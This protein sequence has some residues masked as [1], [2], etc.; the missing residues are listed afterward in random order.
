VPLVTLHTWMDQQVA[1]V[2]EIL[3]TMKVRD[4]GAS[5]LRVN[6]PVFRYGHCNFRPLEALLSFA[7]VVARVM[8]A[9]PAGAEGLLPEADR[10]AYLQAR[11]ARGYP[12]P[13]V[14]GSGPTGPGTTPKR[15]ATTGD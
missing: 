1:Y 15:Q 9:P 12:Q 2:Q 3:Y 8:G 13:T 4:A 14:S 11:A 7:I 6:V 5:A 10:A